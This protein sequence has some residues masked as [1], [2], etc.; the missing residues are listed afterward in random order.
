MR[1]L[2]PDG[3]TD[4]LLWR[5]GGACF[6]GACTGDDEPRN[7][8]PIRGLKNTLPL[9]WDGVLGDPFG[10]GNGAVGGGGSGGT[11]CAITSGDPDSD[12]LCFLD[13]VDGALSGVMCDQTGTCNPGGN[14]LTLAERDNMATFQAAVQYP[15]ARERRIDDAVSTSA[16]LGFRDFFMDQGG[17]GGGP[18][19]CADSD[20]GCHELPLGAATNSATLNGFDAP[21]MRGMTDRFLQFSLGVTAAEEA[22]IFA[23]G[24]GLV[25]PGLQW[26]PSVGF[27]E[28][29]TFAGAFVIFTPVYGVGPIDI[30][31]MFEEASTGTSGATGR[32]VTLHSSL[33]IFQARADAALALLDDLESADARGV[34]N[35]RGRAVRNG[36]PITV[37]YDADANLYQAGQNQ[38]TRATL[39]AEAEAGTLTATLTGRLPQNW[40]KSTHMQPLLSVAG[41]G[42]T[43]DPGVPHLP[44]SGTSSTDMGITGTW[45][46]SDSVIVLNGQPVGGTLECCSS[47]ASNGSC[48]VGGATFGPYCSTELIRIDLNS[49]PSPENTHLLQL[50]NPD[51]PLSNELPIC[52][53]SSG[54]DACL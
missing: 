29:T 52:V 27:R 21:T 5:I 42:D 48:N 23:A 35:L 37:S 1:Q 6:F 44:N 20:A 34:I 40:G 17:I 49:L 11:D 7:T 30:F 22:Q 8:M 54:V 10:G 25:P 43:G 19:T 33:W 45:V 32:Q 31:Q 13:L 16:N 15:P 28:I 36:S 38:I 4:Q 18:D 46:R 41:N 51:G 9:H 3:N 26:S 12:H 14:Q 50:Q 47:I 2:H 39:E 53:D 24:T